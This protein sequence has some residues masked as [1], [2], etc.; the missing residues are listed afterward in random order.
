MSA[1]HELPWAATGEDYEREAAALS[2][3]LQ[4]RENSALWNFKWMHPHFRGKAVTDVD[5]ATLDLDD[6][7]LVVAHEYGFPAWF[8][9]MKFADEVAQAAPA[10]QFERA[11][12]AV[13][14][15]DIA[16]LKTMI[17]DDPQL[18]H[19]RSAR[20]HRATLLHY[21]AANGVEGVRQ[22]TPPNAMEVARLLLDAGADPDALA[23][24][25]DNLCTTMSMLVSSAHPAGAGLQ[26]DLAELLL[27]YGAKHNGPGSEWQ[28]DIMTA[29][30]F[31]YW[32]TADRLA[33]RGAPTDN[34]P[35]AA[36]LGRVAETTQFLPAADAQTR[37]IALAL[38]AQHGHAD[39]VRVL[40]DAGEDPNQFCPEGFH[41]HATPLHNAISAGRDN[42][43]RLLLDRGART[44]IRDT[45][46][47]G[48]AL[49]WAL[50]CQK[51]EI[52]EELRSRGAP[53]RSAQ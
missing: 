50:Y 36:G 25:Y 23:M 40:L 34:L 22:K 53:A 33:K 42:V 38:A 4:A 41:S 32:K 21:I 31:G 46:F 47:D 9:L 1:S 28:S 35:A 10:A 11:V 13:V 17:R 2:A 37:R 7:R 51:P 14:S 20:F 45:I 19:R 12:D 44:D 6:A 16:S 15:G 52:A 29:L 43:V 3:A 26:A 5:P 27:D 18:V 39:V 49:D 48:T 8:N 30:V 24:M